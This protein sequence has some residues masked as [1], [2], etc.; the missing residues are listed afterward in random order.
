M[1]IWI[2]ILNVFGI[3][4]GAAWAADRPESPPQDVTYCQLAKD[5]DSFV[6][7]LIRV[8]ALYV[9]GFEV[10]MLRVPSLLPIARAEDGSHV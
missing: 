2:A 5:P 9:Y 4:C 8:R 7:K 1:K 10:Q 6:G 3:A